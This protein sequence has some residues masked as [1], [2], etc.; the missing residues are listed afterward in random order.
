MR[1]KMRSIKSLQLVNLIKTSLWK[2]TQ[3][4]WYTLRLLEQLFLS[5]K[6]MWGNEEKNKI[7]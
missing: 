2:H 6:A 1:K 5:E 7:N 3:A 4:V